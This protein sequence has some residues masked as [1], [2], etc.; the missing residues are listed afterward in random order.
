MDNIHEHTNVAVFDLG[1]VQ[2]NYIYDIMQTP[3][4]TR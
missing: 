1:C 2:Y 4:P 3:T